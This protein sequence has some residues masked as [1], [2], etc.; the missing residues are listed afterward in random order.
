MSINT[1]VYLIQ[2]SG[3][4]GDNIPDSQAIAE[5]SGTNIIQLSGVVMRQSGRDYIRVEIEDMTAREVDYLFLRKDGKTYYYFVIGYNM[6]AQRTCELYLVLDGLT[7]LN[8]LANGSDVITGWMTRKN[9]TNAEM[10]DISLAAR[11]KLSEPFAPSEELVEDYSNNI[12]GAKNSG[13]S[14]LV[15]STTDLSK[16]TK[17]ATK[18]IADDDSYVTVPDL[19]DLTPSTSFEISS[20]DQGLDS[21]WNTAGMGIY[22]GTNPKVQK[23]I[24]QNWSLGVDS[25]KK[26]YVLPLAYGS[27][28]EDA[29]GFVD[30]ITSNETVVSASIAA[31]PL[32]YIPE[33]YKAAFIHQIITLRSTVSGESA[34]YSAAQIAGSIVD[35]LYTFVYWANPVPD[36]APYCKPTSI[37]GNE[38]RMFGAVRGSNWQTA[39]FAN[40]GEFGWAQNKKETLINGMSAKKFA[41]TVSLA[42]TYVNSVTATENAIGNTALTAVK[43]YGG[44]I[45]PSN[46]K[47]AGGFATAGLTT[48]GGMSQ[49]MNI[50]NKYKGIRNSFDVAHNLRSPDIAFAAAGD[51]QNFIGNDFT[52]TRERFNLTDIIRLDEFLHK[53]GESVSETFTT[54]KCHTRSNFNYIQV[55]RVVLKGSFPRWVSDIAVSQLS[56]GVRVWHTKPNVAALQIGG[57]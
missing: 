1:S 3:W 46:L 22:K 9:K 2:D 18:Y 16:T 28:P 10:Q 38:S 53:Y 17:K 31:L 57:N 8:A 26:S 5:S 39:P 35:G 30:K 43:A 23:G 33:N 11:L 32:D 6:L 48:L 50:A 47:G 27:A 36:G 52:V 15:Q 45:S 24:M 40:S 55:E 56:S 14:S 21:A 37:K 51:M 7:T 4:D 12:V 19:S 13:F 41:D 54:G 20:S 49:S 44:D 34:S 25:I 29:D 42:G